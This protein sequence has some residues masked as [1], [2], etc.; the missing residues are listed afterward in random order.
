MSMRRYGERTENKQQECCQA[1][2]FKSSSEELAEY[3]KDIPETT[4]FVFVEAEIDK[5]GKLY[6][7]VQKKGRAMHNLY[8]PKRIHLLIKSDNTLANVSL[9]ANSKNLYLH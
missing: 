7:A 9:S 4:S 3:I 8:L 2:F 1:P 5:R 6:K